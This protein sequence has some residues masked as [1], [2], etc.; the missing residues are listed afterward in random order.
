VRD[1]AWVAKGAEIEAVF[2]VIVVA[3]QLQIDLINK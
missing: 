3:Q 1:H 2:G